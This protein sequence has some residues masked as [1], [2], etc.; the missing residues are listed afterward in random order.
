[1]YDCLISFT[2]R[3]KKSKYRHDVIPRK[4]IILCLFY[5]DHA[6]LRLLRFLSDWTR[7]NTFFVFTVY[8]D[9]KKIKICRGAWDTS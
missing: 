8:I 6:L 4:A 9:I 7:R 2:V 1:M 5:R 3:T